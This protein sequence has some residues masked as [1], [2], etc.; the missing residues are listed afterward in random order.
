MDNVTFSA[1]PEVPLDLPFVKELLDLQTDDPSNMSMTL[2][3]RWY[4]MDSGK[5]IDEYPQLPIPS[6]CCIMINETMAIWDILVTGMQS[7]EDK[8]N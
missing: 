3:G 7:G 1:L 6:R 8:L 2:N 5:D 4:M